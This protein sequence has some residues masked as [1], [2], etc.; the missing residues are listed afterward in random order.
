MSS[1]VKINTV[2]FCSQTLDNILH[3]LK[4][5]GYT[6]QV[7]KNSISVGNFV[8]EIN[9]EYYYMRI[10]DND[11]STRNFFSLLNKKLADVEIMVQK[12][13]IEQNRQQQEE[14]KKNEE[15]YR[16]RRLKAEENQLKYQK[17]K[18][19]LE[20]ISFV[21]AK[22]Q[23]II[24]KAKEKG[25]SVKETVEDGKIKLRLIKRVY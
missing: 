2:N 15:N 7:N 16:I 13:S 14:A 6:Y 17:E 1:H 3:S 8:I 22:K 24:A 23:A 18:F 19:E 5:L 20:K 4:V 11:Q 21:E 12:Q 25:Y 9:R 10:S